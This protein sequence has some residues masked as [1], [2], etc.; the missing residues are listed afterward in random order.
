MQENESHVTAARDK[1]LAAVFLCERR[2]V[3]LDPV[4]AH[5]GQDQPIHAGG[6]DKVGFEPGAVVGRAIAAEHNE[7]MG[8]AELRV[9]LL[10]QR[11][12]HRFDFRI[13]LFCLGEF[14]VSH[15]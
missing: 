2:I 1:T 3:Q 10:A 6:A 13:S 9:L 15:S 12:N 4:L 5:Q 14:L 8:I 11:T 7:R